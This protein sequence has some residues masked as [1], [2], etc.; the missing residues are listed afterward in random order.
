M[1]SRSHV[2]ATEPNEDL[3][4]EIQDCKMLQYIWKS[5]ETLWISRRSFKMGLL[6]QQLGSQGLVNH[7]FM[8]ERVELVLTKEARF[9]NINAKYDNDIVVSKEEIQDIRNKALGKRK[10]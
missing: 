7:L 9:V 10:L 1:L 4:N 6:L 8:V 3:V 5:R 2:D